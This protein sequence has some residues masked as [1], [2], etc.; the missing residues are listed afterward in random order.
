MVEKKG[1]VMLVV[2]VVMVVVVV[3]TM[4]ADVVVED[5]SC[6][7]FITLDGLYKVPSHELSYFS[8]QRKGS[9]QENGPQI[10]VH[11]NFSFSVTE[12]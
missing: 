10:R 2:M 12:K 1:Q 3:A 7:I 6:N 9:S 8:Y 4:V 11:L 5:D